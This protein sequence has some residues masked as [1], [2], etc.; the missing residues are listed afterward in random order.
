VP[1]AVDVDYEYSVIHSVDDPVVAHTDAKGVITALEF[2]AT[3]ETRFAGERLHCVQNALLCGC[4][5]FASPS[6]TS[7]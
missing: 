7:C 6:S 4:I 5:K 1:D 2:A 3:L